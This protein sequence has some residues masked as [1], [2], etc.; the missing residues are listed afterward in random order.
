MEN[1]L[2]IAGNPS[3]QQT[4]LNVRV[5][6]AAPSEQQVTLSTSQV[7]GQLGLTDQDVLRLIARGELAAYSVADRLHVEPEDLKASMKI[8]KRWRVPTD[9]SEPLYD[10]ERKV[11]TKLLAAMSAQVTDQIILAEAKK[12][13]RPGQPIESVGSVVLNY[14]SAPA[15]FLADLASPSNRGEFAVSIRG[16]Q[17]EQPTS[18]GFAYAKSRL[19]VAAN[20]IESRE[21]AIKGSFLGFLYSSPDVYRATIK[22]MNDRVL[23]ESISCKETRLVEYQ[24][25]EVVVGSEVQ[26]TITRLP[27]IVSYVVP[28]SACDSVLRVAKTADQVF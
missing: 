23:G 12:L 3:N 16:E 10:I 25:R 18:L 20:R 6:S 11:R 2:S 21:L 27:I 24:S 26:R 17:P 4:S 22:A 13:V 1:L 19:I 28:L 9:I 15:S 5:V 8:A 14:A 7:A